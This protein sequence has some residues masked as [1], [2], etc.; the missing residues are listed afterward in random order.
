M[1]KLNEKTEEQKY[2]YGCLM[3]SV[4]IPDWNNLVNKLVDPKDIYDNEVKEYGAEINPHCT[5]LYG[6]HDNV[7]HEQIMPYLMPSHFIKVEFNNISIFENKEYDVLKF[8]LESNALTSMNKVIRHY[9]DYTNDYSDYHPH[10]TIAYLKK[11]KGKKYIKK[12]SKPFTL[13]PDNYIYSYPSGE[14]FEF[15]IH[16]IEGYTDN[17]VIK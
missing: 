10:V 1:K 14:K 3:C 16:P 9:F 6:F 5:I 11:G 12:L 7:N 8:D 2:E 15:D 17:I 13:V 4:K